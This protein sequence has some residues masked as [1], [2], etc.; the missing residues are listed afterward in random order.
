MILHIGYIISNEYDDRLPSPHFYINLVLTAPI[1][2]SGE[3][4]LKCR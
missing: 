3:T 2:A 1:D 4:S